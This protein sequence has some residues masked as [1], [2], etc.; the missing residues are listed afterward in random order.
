MTVDWGLHG[1]SQLGHDTGLEPALPRPV[2]EDSPEI[3]PVSVE[4]RRAKRRREALV[5]GGVVVDEPPPRDECP[6]AGLAGEVAVEELLDLVA[7]LLLADLD[8]GVLEERGVE[9]R[10]RRGVVDEDAGLELDGEYSTAN[11]GA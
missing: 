9:R 8:G 6:V 3:K 11:H 2:V 7:G 4:Q 10:R 1:P 5:G